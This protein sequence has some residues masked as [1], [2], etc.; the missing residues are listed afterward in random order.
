MLLQSMN[1]NQHEKGEITFMK[2]I[3]Q[4]LNL[5]SP[6]NAKEFIEELIDTAVLIGSCIVTYILI[7]I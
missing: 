4:E 5:E 1:K 3:M 7:L 2:K 6:K